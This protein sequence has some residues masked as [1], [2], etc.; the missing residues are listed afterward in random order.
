ME[1]EFPVEQ[2][3][4]DAKHV[5][6]GTAVM[7]VVLSLYESPR[8]T[9]RVPKLQVPG[10]RCCQ[11]EWLLENLIRASHYGMDEDARGNLWTWSKLHKPVLKKRWNVE[12]GVCCWPRQNIM[13]F[14]TVSSVRYLFAVPRW[15][16]LFGLE[17][18]TIGKINSVR[19]YM[20]TMKALKLIMNLKTAIANATITHLSEHGFVEHKSQSISLTRRFLYLFAEFHRPRTRLLCRK[21]RRKLWR[22]IV[23]WKQN[24]KFFHP[25]VFMSRGNKY[26]SIVR[27]ILLKRVLPRM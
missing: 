19:D 8:N 17:T 2:V 9:P 26:N 25:L 23:F 5:K 20:Q 14:T 10:E 1:S 24:G 22:K 13:C 27:M 16:I 21:F 7:L 11:V 15:Y 3:A 4:F 18:R 6:Q 12:G